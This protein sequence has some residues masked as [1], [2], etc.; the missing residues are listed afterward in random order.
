MA[1]SSPFG[2]PPGSRLRLVPP[3]C[4]R[5]LDSLLV[6]DLAAR[7]SGSR[8]SRDFGFSGL[9]MILTS[10]VR[11]WFATSLVTLLVR[12]LAGR[13][14]DY[15]FSDFSSWHTITRDCFS[16]IY[17]LYLYSGLLL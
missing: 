13:S 1:L 6:R 17:L 15:G 5:F 12:D 8:H 7:F 4:L 10:L 16:P 11:S 2:S 3:S 9:L 14:R